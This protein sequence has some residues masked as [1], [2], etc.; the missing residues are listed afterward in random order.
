MTGKS[1]LAQPS[2][3]T[4]QAATEG[5]RDAVTTLLTILLLL[6]ALAALL[7]SAWWVVE[8]AARLISLP[9]TFFPAPTR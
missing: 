7:F 8:T 1:T 3:R 4:D 9:P 6:L 5:I 2:G